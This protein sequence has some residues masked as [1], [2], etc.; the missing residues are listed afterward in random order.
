MPLVRSSRP[1]PESPAGPAHEVDAAALAT[2]LNSPNVE[3]RARAVRVL[4]QRG[5]VDRLVAQL[6][7]EAEPSVRSAILTGVVQCKDPARAA[8]L[9]QHLRSEDVLLRNAVIEAIQ[10]MGDGI[11]PTVEGLLSDPDDDVRLFSVNILQSVNSPRAPDIALAVALTDHN[12]NVCAGA[13]DI[14]AE[15]GRP[16]MIDALATVAGRF[17]Q[18]PF[19]AFAVRV[20][21]K[22][23][24]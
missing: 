15:R 7:I 9:L 19:L 11:L 2:A 16:D 21:L 4:T 3:D 12:V 5:D 6:S 23:I 24:G 17:P 10:L 18:H 22:Q 13:V 8:P 20:A 14:L 1:V